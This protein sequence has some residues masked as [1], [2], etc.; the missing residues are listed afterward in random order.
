[1]KRNIPVADVVIFAV[2]GILL[3]LLGNRTRLPV[4][5]ALGG[6]CVGLA[7]ASLLVG[8]SPLHYFRVSRIHKKP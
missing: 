2:P 5:E 4:L 6:L 7:L 3:W 8:F 1:M